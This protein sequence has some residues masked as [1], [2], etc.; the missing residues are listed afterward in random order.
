[1]TLHSINLYNVTCISP[2]T[3]SLT[4]T[5]GN[6]SPLLGPDW[7]WTFSH[8]PLHFPGNLLPFQVSQKINNIFPSIT[9]V[10]IK[11]LSDQTLSL[12]PRRSL[13]CQ[14]IT[15][16]KNLFFSFVLNS[17]ITI[18]L[19]TAVANNSEM[20]QRNPVGSPPSVD[21]VVRRLFVVVVVVVVFFHG[22]PRPS[23]QL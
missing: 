8:I 17:V 4:P 5:D 16:H 2:P 15:L 9:S 19:L 1:M 7:T 20:V 11:R 22:S 6:E 13:S 12:S 14:R 23:D 10:T 21:V 3:R 18:I